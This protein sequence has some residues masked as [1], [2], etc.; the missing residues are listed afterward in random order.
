MQVEWVYGERPRQPYPW[1]RGNY[2]EVETLSQLFVWLVLLL[3]NVTVQSPPALCW[4][5]EDV[6][7]RCGALQQRQLVSITSQRA[8]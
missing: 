5:F 8:R 3:R 6:Q 4:E 7:G 2:M 1:I